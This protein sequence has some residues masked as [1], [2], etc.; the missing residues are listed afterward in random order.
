MSTTAEYTDELFLLAWGRVMANFAN[1]SDLLR[2]EL[3]PFREKVMAA[4]KHGR[5]CIELAAQINAITTRHVFA[6]VVPF[7]LMEGSRVKGAADDH[8]VGWPDT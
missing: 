6:R 5:P 8:A 4:A 3:D 2:F 1:L 7:D